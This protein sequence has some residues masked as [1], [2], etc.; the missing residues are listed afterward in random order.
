[1]KLLLLFTLVAV[2]TILAQPTHATRNEIVHDLF[3]NQSSSLSSL[4]TNSSVDMMKTFDDAE[5]SGK[6]SIAL[7]AAYSFLLPGMGELYAGDYGSGKYFTIA[8][9]ALW[10]TLL[11]FDRYANWLQDDARR[12]AVQHADVTLNGQDDRFFN[13]VGDFDSVQAYNEEVYRSRTP[14]KQYDE[15]LNSSTYWQWDTPANRQVYRD[16]RVSSDERFNDTRFVAAVIGINHLLSAI[17]AAR[18]TVSHNKHLGQEGT[19][20]FHANL[21]GGIAHPNGILL[22]VSHRF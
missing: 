7:A 2:Q 9:G 19:L 12:Y 21:L 14:N 3:S 18:L 10:I 1:M 5:P 6:K 8:E 11:S 22:S 16:T 13:A 15:N 17:N 20:D 4:N